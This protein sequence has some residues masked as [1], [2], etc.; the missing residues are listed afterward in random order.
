MTEPVQIPAAEIWQR[1][2]GESLRDWVQH[3]RWYASKSRAVA[4][5]DIVESLTLRDD[6]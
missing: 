5:L 6:P 3:Q 2:G 4:S 1:L